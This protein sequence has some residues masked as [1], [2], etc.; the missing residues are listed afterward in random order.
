MTVG[1]KHGPG[2]HQNRFRAG[3]VEDV[4]V[5]KRRT[6]A[7]LHEK[8]D[9][10]HEMY[11]HHNLEAYLYAYIEGVGISGNPKHI[12]FPLPSVA[13]AFFLIAR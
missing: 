2:C 3:R 10:R 1:T 13:Q 4:Y 9:K 12:L 8:G 11:C 7:R 6:W 5:Q